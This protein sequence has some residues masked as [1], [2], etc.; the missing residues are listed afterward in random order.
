ML[1]TMKREFEGHVIPFWENMIDREYGGYYG[2]LDYDLVLDKKA[3]KGCILN[4]RILWFF[5]N[6]Y[7]TLKDDRFLE[8]A[9]QAYDFLKKAFYDE[10]NGGVFWSVTYD[11]KPEE[12]LKHTYNLAFAIYGLASY[13]DAVKDEEVLRLAMR[14]FRTIEDRC[15]DEQGYLEAFTRSFGNMSNE[16][17]SEN[18]VM[19]TRTM[20]TLLHVM[21][22][23]TELYRVN[24]D[25]EVKSKICEILSIFRNKIFNPDRE[26]M[27]V[28]FDKDYNTLIDLHSF[29]HDIETAW[30]IDRTVEVLGAEG[31]EYD[32]SDITGVLTEK[33]YRDCFRT[34][35]LPAESENGVVDETYV[36]WVQ[37][38]T[39]VGFI[40][41]YQKT[42]DRKYL[43][44]AERTWG[45]IV[46]YLVDKREGSEWYSDVNKEGVPESR[47][48]IADEWTCP[49]H[50]GR[51]Y[52]EVI[53]RRLEI[54]NV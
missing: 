37:C 22:A 23:Y 35:S 54:E 7:L 49:Y 13:F 40:N 4:S 30:L 32:M 6:A 9:A 28:F 8:Y 39:V 21:E 2:L 46:K 48:P 41:G 15:R 31:T 53:R 50:N 45:F 16:K 10:E 36:W 3:K 47:K 19:A 25:E 44:A 52:F 24:G 27:E 12:D 26:R 34:D 5:S 51:M 17:L 42:G 43:E 29:G 1:D 11:G 14:I 33:I 38:E 20:N 18:G